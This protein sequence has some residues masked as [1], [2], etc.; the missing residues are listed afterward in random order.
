MKK[1]Q[2]THPLFRTFFTSKLLVGSLIL[3]Y[4]LNFSALAA[5]TPP[6]P[7]SLA[8]LESYLKTPI[9]KASMKALTKAMKAAVK[10][11]PDGAADYIEAFIK[12]GRE[13]SC[14]DT[15]KM[16]AA[17]IAALGENPSVKLVTA[18]VER[19]VTVSPKCAP[20]IVAAA[21]KAAP[22]DFADEIV[23]IAVASVENPEQMVGNVT[24]VEAII[25]AALEGREGLD[26]QLLANAA[27]RGLALNP[28]S[29]LAGAMPSSQGSQAKGELG[30][31][32]AY[33]KNPNITALLIAEDERN[34][35]A[36]SQP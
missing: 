34:A 24:L 4:A 10:A 13:E 7:G 11:N 35:P 12:S 1:L 14:A 25:T 2:N 15:A 33:E 5:P 19:A 16:I 20:A 22:A 9:T 23:E 21:V 30:G 28:S 8:K 27:D 36:V 18:I 29:L 17:A 3:G 31:V 32:A 6:P 26:R